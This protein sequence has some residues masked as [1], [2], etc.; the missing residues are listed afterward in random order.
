VQSRRDPSH[1]FGFANLFDVRRIRTSR[2]ETSLISDAGQTFQCAI[3]S[4]STAVRCTRPSCALLIGSGR[5]LFPLASCTPTRCLAGG[6]MSFTQ[7]LRRAIRFEGTGNWFGMCAVQKSST[8][9]Q[10]RR[11]RINRISR[12]RVGGAF[13]SHARHADIQYDRQRLHRRCHWRR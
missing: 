1:G 8:T 10:V 13:F 11:P 2:I 6:E 12:R 5:I 3:P 4:R 9:Y 7:A